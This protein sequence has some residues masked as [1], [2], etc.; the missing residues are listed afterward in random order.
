MLEGRTGTKF[1]ASGKESAKSN[2]WQN[3][4]TISEFLNGI[5]KPYLEF[6]RGDCVISEELSAYP[7]NQKA[8]IIMDQHWSHTDAST[9]SILSDLK[10]DTAHL[11]PNSTDL[12]CALDVGIC[13]PLKSCLRRTF[14]QYCASSIA[15]QLD[16]NIPASNIKVNLRLSALKPLAGQWI[17]SCYTY[18]QENE[19]DLV[20]NAWQGAFNNLQK[21]ATTSTNLQPINTSNTKCVTKF[22]Q[23]L[24]VARPR[25]ATPSVALPVAT[26]S[27]TPPVHITNLADTNDTNNVEAGEFEEPQ[28]Q[29]PETEI[30]FDESEAEGEIT[31]DEREI[32]EDDD[33][34]TNPVGRQIMVYWSDGEGQRWESGVVKEKYSKVKFV[35]TYDFLVKAKEDDNTVD[36]DVIE[37]LL[38]KRAVQWRFKSKK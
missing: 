29:E 23:A 30:E 5:I 31:D 27:V 11:Y 13:K 10:C 20:K 32:T 21:H 25:E 2:K 1:S 19:T 38:G 18:L 12:F 17:S 3:R 6:C 35:I 36:A 9:A 7:K 34:D 26:S 28:A 33:D 4:K 16:A 14:E 37:N 8:L 15:S 24:L 22:I